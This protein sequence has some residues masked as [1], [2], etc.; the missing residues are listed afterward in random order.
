MIVRVSL[1]AGLAVLGDLVFES[2]Q[3]MISFEPLATLSNTAFELTKN[4]VP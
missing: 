1:G 4:S 2:A 3:T